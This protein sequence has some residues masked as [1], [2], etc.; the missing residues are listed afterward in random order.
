MAKFKKGDKVKISDD[1]LKIHSRSVPA[2]MGHTQDTINWRCSLL[3]IQIAG[4]VGEIERTFTNS[5]HVNV[6]FNNQC[7]GVDEYMLK[8]EVVNG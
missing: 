7:Y 2:H 8:K 4:T 1:G 6:L 5:T 3:E